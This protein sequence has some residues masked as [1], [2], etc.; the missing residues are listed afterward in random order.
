MRN[1][2][3][4]V[5]GWGNLRKSGYTTVTHTNTLFLINA[6]EGMGDKIPNTPTM[7]TFFSEIFARFPVEPFVNRF[8]SADTSLIQHP[9]VQFL[10][11]LIPEGRDS[12]LVSKKSEHIT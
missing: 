3:Q 1:N 11:S 9:P 5:N 6:A 7:L 4:Q 10:L 2:V 12:P 8:Q